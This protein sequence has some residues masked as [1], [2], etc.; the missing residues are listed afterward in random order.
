MLKSERDAYKVVV[1]KLLRARRTSMDLS[2]NRVAEDAG[3]SQQTVSYVERG[4]RDPTLDTLLR[5]L[6]VLGV[7]PSDF[8]LQCERT[9]GQ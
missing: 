8:F 1:R 6:G 3:I 5:I 4:L 2:M 9:L 7:K